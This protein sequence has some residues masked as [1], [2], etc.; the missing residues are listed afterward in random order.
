VSH[1]GG[2]DFLALDAGVP[3]ELISFY[4]LAQFPLVGQALVMAYNISTLGPNDPA[5]VR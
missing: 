4:G 2:Q 5:L 3:P 1:R